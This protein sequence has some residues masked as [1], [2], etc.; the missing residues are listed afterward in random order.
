MKRVLVIAIALCAAVPARADRAKA[1]QYFRAG[2][3][4]FRQQSFEAAAED[5]EAAYKELPLPDIAFSAAQAYR[6]QYFID[7]KPRYVQRAVQLY[8]IYLAAVKTG[9][10]VGDASDGLAEMKRELDKLGAQGA[11]V[12]TTQ[13]AATRLAVSVV[14]A[15]DVQ[16]GM[17]ELG[18]M[19]AS[20]AP[21]AK[22]TIDGK[23]VELFVPVD[24]SPGE[25]VIAV[26]AP[27]FYPVTIKR[28]AV[29][30]ASDVVEAQLQPEPAQL[31]L[32][33][34]HGAHVSIDGKPVGTTPLAVQALPAGHHLVAISAR[35]HEPVIRELQLARDQHLTLDAPLA[36]TGKRKAVPWLL[37]GAGVLAVASG[38]T[39]IIAASADSDL[40]KL[41]HM[42]EQSGITAAQYAQ[43]RNDQDRRDTFRSAAFVLGGAAVVT[44]AIAAA[45]YWFDEPTPG[46]R[47]LVPAVVPGGVGLS[48][49]GQF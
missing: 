49:S 38:G 37:G 36:K 16:Q 10:R 44:G 14:T 47:A 21:K 35:G 5:F 1:E 40:A 25:H 48:L 32:H 2:A 6:R 19:P 11:R 28:V 41:E 46:E 7:P 42:R 33:T 26:A 31:T 20:E 13:P 12:D 3:Q 15:G 22:A 4:A 23:P 45:L 18:A 24:V 17:S 39:A 34:E 30:G 29:E 43:L 9:G 8:E 27:G